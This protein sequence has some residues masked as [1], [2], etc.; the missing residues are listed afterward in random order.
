[1]LKEKI[2]G[3]NLNYIVIDNPIP[4]KCSFK[5][6]SLKINLLSEHIA[7][8]SVGSVKLQFAPSN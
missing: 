3:K 4:F 2:S 7:T 8:F 5:E 1:M 6:I